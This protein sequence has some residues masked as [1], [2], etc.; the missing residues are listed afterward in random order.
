MY[1]FKLI[2]NIKWFIFPI[3]IKI[4]QHTISC[5]NIKKNTI[6]GVNIA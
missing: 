5:V 4:I 3:T 6:Y 2:L 1:N